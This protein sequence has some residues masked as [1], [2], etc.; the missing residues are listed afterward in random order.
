VYRTRSRAANG[1]TE[2]WCGGNEG[3][4]IKEYMTA[5]SGGALGKLW[6][7]SS[8]QE[9]RHRNQAVVHNTSTTLP[10]SSSDALIDLQHRVNM[11]KNYNKYLKPQTGAQ[12]RLQKL[13]TES[14]NKI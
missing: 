13:K 3:G 11:H 2:G 4:R 14:K 8:T 7:T 10:K 6:G 9:L 1:G 12:Y 5:L